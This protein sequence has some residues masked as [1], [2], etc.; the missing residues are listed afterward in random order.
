VFLAFDRD[1]RAYH[2]SLNV[3]NQIFLNFQLERKQFKGVIR[4][5]ILFDKVLELSD[6][7]FVGGN[8]HCLGLALTYQKFFTYG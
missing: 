4:R 7:N 8:G 5:I 1:F 2:Y 3:V 6:F